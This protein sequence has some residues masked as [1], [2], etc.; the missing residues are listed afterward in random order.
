MPQ[1]PCSPG[2]TRPAIRDHQGK[3]HNL[4]LAQKEVPGSQQNT[5]SI[6]GFAQGVARTTWPVASEKASLTQ[7]RSQLTGPCR[8]TV[9]RIQALRSLWTPEST[10]RAVL[11]VPHTVPP[12]AS[13]FTGSSVVE[14]SPRRGCCL[15]CL[16]PDR[17][18]PDGWSCPIYLGAL[19]AWH[20]ADAEY[21]F[22]NQ[23]ERD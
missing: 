2:E 18:P 21:M 4:P 9:L 11:A 3:Q 6:T 23:F 12:T 19:R 15:P 5:H 7:H 14:L 13:C 22:L 8:P 17:R 20:T 10:P 1:A 16:P